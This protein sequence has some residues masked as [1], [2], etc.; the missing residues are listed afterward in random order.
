MSKIYK[1]ITGSTE[2]EIEDIE[3]IKISK[4]NLTNVHDTDS[5]TV[6]LYFKNYKITDTRLEVGENGDYNELEKTTYTYHIIKNVIIPVG[7][8]ISF[9]NS[10]FNGINY[11]DYR[12]FIKLAAG[13]SAVD[14]IIYGNKSKD[15]YKKSQLKPY[16]I[17]QN[18]AGYG[19]D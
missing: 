16:I 2:V 15:L 3:S 19:D 7:A 1:N 12:L 8:S 5:A 14:L 11:Y 4:L 18:D 17:P 10:Y 9:D 6:N 13:T